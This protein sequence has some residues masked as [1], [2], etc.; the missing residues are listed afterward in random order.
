[1]RIRYC[2]I[3]IC[4]SVLMADILSTG[5]QPMDTPQEPK[6]EQKP[7]PE[8]EPEPQPET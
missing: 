5:C 8:P 3:L 4:I 7:E 2:I 1:M 6:E